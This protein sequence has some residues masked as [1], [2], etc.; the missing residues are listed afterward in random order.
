MNVEIKISSR[1]IPYKLSLKYL[2]KR[3]ND[4]KL[5]KKKDLIWLLE[6]PLIFTGGIRS[7]DIDILDKN[8]KVIKTKRGGKITLH[9][10]G[11][12]IIYFVVNLNK[13]KK[14]IRKFVNY[15]ENSIIEFLRLFNIESKSDRKN[16]GIWVKDKKIAAI[17]IRVSRW[18]AYHG[19]SINISN[20]LK[21]YKKI[22][23]CGLKNDKVTSIKNENKDIDIDINKALKQIFLKNFSEI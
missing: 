14:D 7:N 15:I 20:N 1:K 12:K 10:P 18:I 8:I 17:G 13:R 2:E 3:V 6:H 19:C 21:D 16:I 23:P 9:N 22:N 5:G 4:V 11:Q